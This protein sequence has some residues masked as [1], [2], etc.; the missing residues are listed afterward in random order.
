MVLVAAGP[1]VQGK[2]L[3]SFEVAAQ[4]VHLLDMS[5]ISLTLMRSVRL[6]L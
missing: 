6:K 1:L 3:L 2:P 5:S 4:A